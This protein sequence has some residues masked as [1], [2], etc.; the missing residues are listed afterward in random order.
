MPPPDPCQCTFAQRTTGD[1]CRYC[2][3]QEYIDRLHEW[4]DEAQEW[5]QA[6]DDELTQLQMTTDTFPDPR[7]AIK[8]LLDWHVQV[9]VDPAVNGGYRLGRIRGGQP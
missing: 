9:A 6:V 5:E 7:T 4:L 1:G 3:P 8:A 2:Q